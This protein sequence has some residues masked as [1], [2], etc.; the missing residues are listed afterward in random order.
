M[1]KI[2][3]I[4]SIA[5]LSAG[6]LSSCSD[7]MMEGEGYASLKVSMNSAVEVVTRATS[8]TELEQSCKVYIKNDRGI[9]RRY[10]GV[11]E[12]PERIVLQSGSYTA[13]VQAGEEAPASF[14]SRYFQGEASFEVKGGQST[15]VQ[16]VGKVANVVASV[17]FDDALNE[18]ITDYSVDI[19]HSNGT[20]AFTPENAAEAKGYYMMPAGDNELKYNLHGKELNGKTFTIQGII[21]ADAKPATEYRV[22]FKYNPSEYEEM[23]GSIVEVVVDENEIEVNE[24]IE[25]EIAPVFMLGGGLDINKPVLG[26]PSNVDRLVAYACGTRDIKEFVVTAQGNFFTTY[27]GLPADSF[28]AVG[29]IGTAREQDYKN[30]GVEFK[31]TFDQK[32]SE[33]TSGDAIAKVAFSAQTMSKLPLGEYVITLTATDKKNRTRTRDITIQITSSPVQPEQVNEQSVYTNRATLL[34]SVLRDGVET[35]GFNYREVGTTAWTYVAGTIGSP[36]QAMRKAAA[37]GDKFYAQVTGLKANTKYEYVTLTEDFVGTT[38]VTFTTEDTR[39][40]ENADFENWDESGTAYLPTAPG[41][42]RWWDSGNHGSTT[43]GS[44]YNITT[45]DSSVRYGDSGYSAKL[46]S[47]YIIMKFAAGNI[48]VGEYLGTNGTNGVLGL[49]R[50]FNSRPTKLKGYVR[51]EG[52]TI[53]RGTLSNIPADIRP[54]EG[55][56]DQGHIYIALCDDNPMSVKAGSNTYSWNPQIVYTGDLTN[57]SFSKNAPQV[58][59]YG[60]KFFTGTTSETGMIEFEIPLDYYDNRKPKYIVVLCAASRF[61][62]YFV[63]GDTSKMW[64]DHFTL[65]Y[66]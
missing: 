63:G 37:K 25:L 32:G 52:S 60:E 5:L 9:I 26:E 20:L 10:R 39:Q 18:V 64:V 36:S 49:G 3:N 50:P 30:A 11:A 59:A 4:L 44:S 57:Y 54:A 41:A 8:L 27:M 58:I 22:H 7:D 24:S 47:R 1:K 40:L 23:G 31:Y 33:E 56:P 17:V 34:G 48:F 62:D 15:P 16:L 38:T 66:E 21:A 29:L 65:V 61:G 12:I 46:A 55:S 51:Y 42:A 19:F 43:L 14:T 2:F 53:N 13:E 45:K 35:V 6:L 28:D